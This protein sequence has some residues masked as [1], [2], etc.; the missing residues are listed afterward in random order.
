MD[1]LGVVLYASRQA[2]MGLDAPSDYNI[3][4]APVHDATA[5]LHR[6]GLSPLAAGDY[7]AGDILLSVVGRHRLHFAVLT[8]RGL[9]EAHA[10]IGRVIERP[11]A[12]DDRWISGWRLPDGDWSTAWRL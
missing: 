3:R 2:G 10:G 11:M 5:A 1:C 12:V 7:R 8:D 4:R 9:V 6:A